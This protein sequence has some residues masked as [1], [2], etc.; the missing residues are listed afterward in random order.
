MI[1]LDRAIE[2]GFTGRGV[3][4]GVMD[5]ILQLD[6]PEYA[7]RL[8]ASFDIETGAS[9]GPTYNDHA[10]HVA[11]TTAGRNV[12]VARG[13]HLVA[14]RVTEVPN[15]VGDPAMTEG[16]LFGLRRG[17]RIFNNSWGVSRRIEGIPSTIRIDEISP[18]IFTAI[19]PGHLEAFRQTSQAGAVQVWATGN[20]SPNFDEQRLEG[21]ANPGFFAGLPVLFPELEPYW[22][23]VTSLDQNG[24]ISVFADRCGV[25]AQWCLADPGEKIISSLPGS[26]YGPLDGTSMATPHVSGAL[27]VAAEIFP[28]ASGPEMVQLVLQ[29][30]TDIGDPGVDPVYG[31]GRLNVGNIVD[32]IEPRTGASFAS[33][34][35]ARSAA[36]GHAGATLRRR[37]SLPSIG[38]GTGTIDQQASYASLNFDQNGG[39][40]G[41]SNPTTTGFWVSPYFG[42]ARL[43]G[44][45]SS[46]TALA[47][48]TGFLAGLDLVQNENARFGAVGGYSQSRLKHRETADEARSDAILAGLY[49]SYRAKN[50]L[51]QGT[52]LLAL[53]DE[54]LTRYEIAGAKGTSGMPVGRSAARGTGLEADLQLGYEFGLADSSTLTP[55]A[56]F[57][58]RSQ[59]TED[60]HETGAGIFSLHSPAQTQSQ[61]GF[62][63][64]LSWAS[65][66]I[67]V[68]DARLRIEA[69][70]GY[71][72]LF[73]DLDHRTTV[74]L[75]GRRI[76]SRTPSVGRN[77]LRL[78]GQL[79]FSNQ[80]ETLSGF[81]SY[82]GA[83]QQR[84]TSHGISA[85]LRISF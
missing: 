37:L 27:A 32:T 81:I 5:S 54:S 85:G 1:N 78:G 36:L 30:A 4:I 72:R 24:E 3:T 31:W 26:S 23:A 10:T 35:W 16:Y 59:W 29:T 62:G 17:V 71:S 13:A 63:P 65:A 25:A 28:A 75:L 9:F 11:G 52:G 56:F 83:F 7:D 42:E 53:F 77:L 74:A 8:V 47:R 50:W 12:G 19:W 22:V 61:F 20:G 44:S 79:S 39:R 14:V 38:T 82:D 34:S 64:G 2:A 15:D 57:T 45:V 48:T 18:E 68:G 60:F 69:D 73:G 84:A 21:G 41:V 80:K 55:Y 70:V 76:E 6:H 58:G 33:A 43:G 51:V 46:P 49:G 66:P 67:V 40:F